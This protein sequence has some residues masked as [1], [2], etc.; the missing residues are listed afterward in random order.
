MKEIVS[1]GEAAELLGVNDQSIRNYVRRGLLIPQDDDPRAFDRDDVAAILESRECVH[2]FKAVVA[3]ALQ[4][5][6]TARAAADRV[7]TLERFIGVNMEPLGLEEEAVVR[8][9]AR[10]QEALRSPP[11]DAAELLEWARA[12]FSMSEEYMDL[13]T[14]YCGEDAWETF[15]ELQRWLPEAVPA[16]RVM[17]EKD[18]ELAYRY[19]EVGRRNL[20]NV[21]FIHVRTH[22]GPRLSNRIFHDEEFDETAKILKVVGLLEDVAREKKAG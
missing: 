9:Y 6:A 4:A 5:R 8:L 3:I 7:E 17:T 1:R 11:D 21:L 2:D 15:Y 13:V 10:A 12:F 18:F 19:L 14:A 16:E 22:Y 20:R